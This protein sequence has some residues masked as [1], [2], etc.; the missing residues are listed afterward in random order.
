LILFGILLNVFAGSGGMVFAFFEQGFGSKRVIM[1]SIVGLILAGSAM[2]LAPS[3]MIFAI[4][5]C[6]LGVFV[7]P[8]QQASRTMMA[9]LAPEETQAE[10][11]GLYALSGKATSALGPGLVAL[12]TAMAVAWNW[13]E[14][15]ALV[16]GMFGVMPFMIAGFIIMLFVKS[17]D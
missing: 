14:A 7:G 9:K 4:F 3:F 6:A 5:G 11:F 12:M 1:T 15:A 16:F 2:L 17:P 8:I 10:L 13:N